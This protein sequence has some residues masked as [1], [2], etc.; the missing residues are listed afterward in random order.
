MVIKWYKKNDPSAALNVAEVLVRGSRGLPEKHKYMPA[1]PEKTIRTVMEER[2][3]GTQWTST[4]SKILGAE[5][6]DLWVRPPLDDA[7]GSAGGGRARK[8]SAPIAAS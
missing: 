8:R 5:Q 6:L 3:K 1:W 7:S 4:S 2:E